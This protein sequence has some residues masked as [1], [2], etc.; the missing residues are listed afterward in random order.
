MTPLEEGLII[1]LH[2]MV[3]SLRYLQDKHGAREGITMF[4]NNLGKHIL[5]AEQELLNIGAFSLAQFGRDLQVLRAIPQDQRYGILDEVLESYAKK[6]DVVSLLYRVRE[7]EQN[8]VEADAG[9]I[10]GFEQMR[11]A[12][13]ALVESY[14]SRNPL[15]KE[16]AEKLLKELENKIK[17]FKEIKQIEIVEFDHHTRNNEKVGRV[18]NIATVRKA[19]LEK[20]EKKLKELPSGDSEERRSLEKTK[21]NLEGMQKFEGRFHYLPIAGDG[22]CLFRAIAVEVLTWLATVKAVGTTVKAKLEAITAHL[23]EQRADVVLYLPEDKQQELANYKKLFDE[24]LETILSATDAMT[25][26]DRISLFM[27]TEDPLLHTFLRDRG[28]IQ[29]LRLLSVAYYKEL[30]NRD[31]TNPEKSAFVKAVIEPSEKSSEK[32][33]V[34]LETSAWGGETDLNALTKVFGVVIQTHDIAASTERHARTFPEGGSPTLHVGHS[35]NHY[36]VLVAM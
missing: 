18:Q 21:R 26:R 22:A 7:Y 19:D 3:D 10:A 11:P 25:M 32:W 33:L 5:S 31:D 34:D 12:F 30:L 36:D 13:Q 4:F 20:A 9:L 8:I 14:G 1:R 28:I 6:I 24:C 23:E 35:E 29:Y 27:N 15:R 17:C 16:E 2:A